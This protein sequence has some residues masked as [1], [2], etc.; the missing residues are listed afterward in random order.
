VYDVCYIQINGLVPLARYHAQYDDGSCSSTL[1]SACINALTEM[2]QNKAGLLTNNPTLGLNSNL[3]GHV[4]P[5]CNAIGNHIRDNFPSECEKFF[6][7]DQH[8]L[9]GLPVTLAQGR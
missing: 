4:L 7:T 9:K 1:D 3:T 5:I 2:A 8:V 6:T